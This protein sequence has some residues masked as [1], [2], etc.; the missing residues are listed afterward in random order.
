MLDVNIQ[1]K[2]CFSESNDGFISDT[3]REKCYNKGETLLIIKSNKNKIFGGFTDIA[4]GLDGGHKGNNGK[5][6]LFSIRD[7]QSIVKLDCIDNEHEVY[8]DQQSLISF[9]GGSL[10]IN[11]D[12]NNS[13]SKLVY[14]KQP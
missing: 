2:L 1:L 4:W 11:L 6:F 8:H 13:K 14:Y 12:F 3:F 5:S 10:D 7:D 9:G